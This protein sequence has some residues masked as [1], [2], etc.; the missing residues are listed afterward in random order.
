MNRSKKA[1]PTRPKRDKL[2]RYADQR[3][4]QALDI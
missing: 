3:N 2:A 4:A 1:A